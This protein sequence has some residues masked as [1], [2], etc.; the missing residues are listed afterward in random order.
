MMD[1][2]DAFDRNLKCGIMESGTFSSGRTRDIDSSFDRARATA[3]EAGDCGG[4][5][6][7]LFLGG[8]FGAELTRPGIC[9]GKNEAALDEEEDEEDDEEDDDEDE[10]S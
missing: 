6:R 9:V 4:T 10:I 5:E 1:L 8:L 3:V 2:C 7:L